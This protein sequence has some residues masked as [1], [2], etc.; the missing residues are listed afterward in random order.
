MHAWL[1]MRA[2]LRQMQR[3]MDELARGWREQGKGG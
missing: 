3:D 2:A 1:L